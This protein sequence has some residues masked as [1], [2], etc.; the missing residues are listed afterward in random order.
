MR[1]DA[2]VIGGGPVGLTTAL[3]LARQGLRVA[4]VEKGT[5]GVGSLGAVAVDDECLRIWQSC[6]LESSL[7]PDWEAGETGAVMCEYV[8]RR[9]KP[10]LRLRQRTTDFG[11]PQAVVIDLP[12]ILA[13]LRRRA[14]QKPS[15]DLFTGCTMTALTQCDTH[16]TI[17][18]ERAGKSELVLQGAW[19][20]ACDGRASP[21]RAVLGVAIQGQT[22]PNPWLVADLED[23]TPQC[24]ARF[25]C[26]RNA[27]A[28]TVPLPNG[29]R[30]VERM[31]P[32]GTEITS[33][34]DDEDTVRGLL[35]DA[36][37]DA[38]GS[39]ILSCTVMRFSAGLA[40]R[41]RVGRVFLA[42]DAAHQTPPFAGQGLSSGLRDASNLAFKLA[43][44]QTGWLSEEVLSTYEVER[45][46]HQRRMIALALRLG[47]VMSPAS[48]WRAAAI[49]V[50]VRACM[51]VPRVRTN[52]ELRGQGTRPVL[53]EG[54]FVRG[55]CSGRMCPQPWV[56][57]G[58]MRRIRFDG[59]LGPRM[60]WLAVG[61]HD[62]PTRV[63]GSLLAPG[64]TILTENHDFSD[65]D[66]MLQRTLGR[67]SIALIRPDRVI[68][69]HHASARASAQQP[70]SSTCLTVPIHQPQLAHSATP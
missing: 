34:L 66:R 23:Q 50:L 17:R 10:F 28:V 36:W 11:Y 39:R 29:H 64:D 24:C 40:D 25:I 61:D 13:K 15:I 54:F 18:C 46:D 8:D 59:L 63:D 43:G 14:E 4:V 38:R 22:L 5:G 31:L 2:L 33:L 12:R 56:N 57:A 70:R 47:S 51:A 69:T 55:G 7:E 30:R 1:H 3:L 68:H 52:F 35:S 65:P 67:G 44:V 27:T 45:R 32:A 58:T 62:R 19:A 53:E 37:G 42:G 48:A 60:T 41:W 6:G 21:T 9:G 49:P 26:E 20:V 16:V